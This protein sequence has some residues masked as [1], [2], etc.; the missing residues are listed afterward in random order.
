MIE[1]FSF[2]NYRSFKDIQTLDL[3]AANIKSQNSELDRKNVI[4][5]GPKS[6]LLKT[7]IISG[8]NSSGKSNV[9]KAFKAFQN[10]FFN[11]YGMVD[12]MSYEP[13]YL[14]DEFMKY[15]T[16]YQIIFIVD[17]IRY[18]Y[19][20]EIDS[21][22]I[23][24][25]WLFATPKLKEL[26][27]FIKEG[28]TMKKIDRSNYNE[29]SRIY[30]LADEEYD[31]VFQENH[32]VLK[33]VAQFKFAK[34]SQSIINYI[35]SIEVID[36][37]KSIEDFRIASDQISIDRKL[38]DFTQNLLDKANT[39]VAKLT[40]EEVGEDFKFKDSE[41]DTSNKKFLYSIKKYGP[42]EN[43][44]FGLHFVDS[45]SEGTKKIFELSPALYNS[46][47]NGTPIFIDE[48]DARLH[49]LLSEKIIELFN[50]DENQKAQLI[51]VSHD[52]NLLDKELLRQDQIVFVEKDKED[53][54]QLYALSDIKG[55]RNSASY[56]KDYLLGKYG[57][58]PNVRNLENVLYDAIDEDEDE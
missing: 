52:T 25:E 14:R 32:L 4:T 16:F 5:V 39:G 1:S 57:A 42:R 34:I 35:K 7:V 31:E 6:K 58:I 47:H 49:T 21:K 22:S 20:Y 29:G 53:S 23:Q 54:S 45:E 17:D 8:A 50:N 2:G 13:F 37:L 51:A 10:S 19:G 9:I 41:Y 28:A 11:F 46:L 15:P 55:V 3:R 18:R 26:P 44:K 30:N 24:A 38:L 43:D 33:S 27:Y 36:G 56:E 12:R 40:Y 48:F